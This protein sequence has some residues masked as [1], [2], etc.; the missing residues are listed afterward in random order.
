DVATPT[1]GARGTK[2]WCRVLGLPALNREGLTRNGDIVEL[3]LSVSQIAPHRHSA[4]R[5]TEGAGVGNSQRS[6]ANENTPIERAAGGR[7]GNR[8]RGQRVGQFDGPCP[9]NLLGEVT[10]G[11]PSHPIPRK[12]EGRSGG[13]IDDTRGRV[14]G[15]NVGDGEYTI[16]HIC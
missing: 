15:V 10:R 11:A 5:R 16:H 12:A 13:D 1:A 6:S 7:E 14:R 8:L 4:G 2:R 9:R 3:Q